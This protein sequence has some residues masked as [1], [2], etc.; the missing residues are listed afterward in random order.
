V[1]FFFCLPVYRRKWQ[2]LL[3]LLVFSALGVASI[4]CAGY[5]V[6][7]PSGGT[8]VGNYIVTVTGSSGT[9]T[10]STTVMITIN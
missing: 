9:A 7:Q 6:D 10:V 5:K 2:T 8:S 3:S 1:L 4:G